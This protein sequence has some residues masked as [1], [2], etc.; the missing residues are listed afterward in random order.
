MMRY[1]RKILSSAIQ[2]SNQQS[3]GGIAVRFAAG[4]LWQA[5]DAGCDLKI[6]GSLTAPPVGVPRYLSRNALFA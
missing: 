3:Q 2:R 1:E 6:A 4:G 5:F